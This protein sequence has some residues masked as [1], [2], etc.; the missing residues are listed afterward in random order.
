MMYLPRAFAETDRDALYAMIRADA[1]GILVSGGD[2]GLTASH[3]PFHL[4]AEG[5]TLVGHLARANPQWR[6]LAERPRA[7]AIFAGAH[8]YVSPGWYEQ[9]E[10]SVPTWNYEAVHV[11]G[12]VRVFH[13]PAELRALLDRLTATYEA[14]RAS[15]WSLDVPSPGFIDRQLREIVG[16][17]LSIE[18][19]KGKRKLSQNRSEADR[20]GVVAGL[21]AEGNPGSRAVAARMGR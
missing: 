5:G 17:A 14:G 13:D 15:P 3:L 7:L 12:P 20:A 4:D 16:I 10:M 19:I 6:G 9:P 18:R 1:F 21:V 2:N 11:S 8:A